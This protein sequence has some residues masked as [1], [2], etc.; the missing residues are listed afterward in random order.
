MMKSSKRSLWGVSVTLAAL[1][2][3]WG[4]CVPAGAQQPFKLRVGAITQD[5]PA[6]VVNVYAAL[7]EGYFKDEGI[8]PVFIY[9]INGPTTLQKMAAGDVDM[10]ISTAI[11]VMFQAIATGGMDLVYVASTIKNNAPLVVRREIKSVSDLNGKRVGTP[12]IGTIQD[13]LLGVFEKQHGIK[14]THVY[15][16][17]TDLLTYFEKGEIDGVAA[18]QPTAELARRKMGAIYLAKAILP[19]AESTGII[20]PRAFIEKH[21]D[22]V[23]RF[24]RAT[25]RG[26]QYFRKNPEAYIEWLAKRENME[27]DILRAIV[28]DRE[29]V[30]PDRP[31]ADR[32]STKLLIRAA[33]D[34]GKIPKE[35]LPDDAAIDAWMAKHI[36]DSFLQAAMKEVQWKDQ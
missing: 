34:A 31:V 26:L 7:K 24:V 25:L 1:I 11:S 23:K 16:R 2:L 10:A 29:I 30:L 33:R 5:A 20:F 28:L 14:T 9:N 17:I 15:G 3:F 4:M 13:T 22:V 8:E 27:A 36:D 32:P 6:G 19:G 21:P 12:G 35:K 18:W